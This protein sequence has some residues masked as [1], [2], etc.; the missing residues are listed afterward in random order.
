MEILSCIYN[1]VSE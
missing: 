1:Y